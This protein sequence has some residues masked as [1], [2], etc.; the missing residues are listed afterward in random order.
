MWWRGLRVPVMEEAVPAGSALTDAIM[1]GRLFLRDQTNG[2]QPNYGL[3]S[4]GGS[5]Q[6]SKP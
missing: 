1:L 2:P 5:P 6:I 4:W 3:N